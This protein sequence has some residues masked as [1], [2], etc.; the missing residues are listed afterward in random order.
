MQV[1]G[2]GSNSG[3]IP[4][5]LGNCHLLFPEGDGAQLG[6][7]LG[8]FIADPPLRASLARTCARRLRAH[9]TDEVIAAKL[10]LRLKSLQ[11]DRS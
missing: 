4:D 5:V 11:L 1:V 6:H 8:T 10:H 2:V 7:R 9:F 3:A